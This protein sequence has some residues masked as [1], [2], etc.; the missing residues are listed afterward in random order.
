MKGKDMKT[1]FFSEKLS[2]ETIH[3]RMSKYIEGPNICD[4]PS[5]FLISYIFL[6]AFI[7]WTFCLSHLLCTFTL[8]FL[9]FY[10]N[11]IL[12]YS[13]YFFYIIFNLYFYQ[14]YTIVTHFIFIHMIIVYNVVHVSFGAAISLYL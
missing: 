6:V 8:G 1:L 11:G 3:S 12:W 2:P 10:W 4:H 7:W 5:L 9:L 14:K 13:F